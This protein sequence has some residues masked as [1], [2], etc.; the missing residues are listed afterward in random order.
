MINASWR[1]GWAWLT[2]PILLVSRCRKLAVSTYFGLIA[3]RGLGSP[4]TL[5]LPDSFRKLSTSG[6]YCHLLGID[7]VSLC[8]LTRYIIPQLPSRSSSVLA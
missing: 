4:P 8:L 6:G 1:R 3:H 5:P 2:D 7:T